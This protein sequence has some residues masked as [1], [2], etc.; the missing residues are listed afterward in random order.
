[1]PVVFLIECGFGSR[2]LQV[3]CMNE[4][5][6][7]VPGG[8]ANMNGMF[9]PGAS[10][11]IFEPLS[12]GVSRDTD[13]GI[14]L[15]VKRF[16]ASE[17]MYRNAVLLDFVDGSFEILFANKC[18]QSN[19]LFVRPNTP[20]DK[21]LSTSARSASSLLIAGSKRLPPRERS[22]RPYHPVLEVSITEFF[23][24]RHGPNTCNFTDLRRKRGGG[25]FRLSIE[26]TV[27]L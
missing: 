16:R 10:I 22:V 18:Q 4:L 3:A 6:N 25:G 15:R 24:V 26:I 20:D 9:R 12:Q 2:Y 27:A 14:H 8:Q 1:M 13:D 23:A 7:V 17:G 11:I 5:G 19:G 21:T